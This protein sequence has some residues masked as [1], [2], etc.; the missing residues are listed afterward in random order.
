[1]SAYIV[2]DIDI[3]DPEAYEQYKPLASAAIEKYGARPL[4]RGGDVETAEGDW[5]P[6]RFVILEFP[7]MEQ[8]RKF[9]D[10]PEYVKARTIRQQASKSNLIFVKGV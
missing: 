10:S 3:T 4:A 6:K 9:Y 2:A 8:L 5:K 1:M 7:S